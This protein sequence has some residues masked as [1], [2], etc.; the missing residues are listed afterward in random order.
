VPRI[1]LQ[2]PLGRARFVSAQRLPSALQLSPDRTADCANAAL[3]RL[4][5]VLGCPEFPQDL[6]RARRSLGASAQSARTVGST[7]R[8]WPPAGLRSSG[9]RGA[10]VVAVAPGMFQSPRRLCSALLQ[11]D[12][13]G[14]RRLPAPGLR[15]PS[16]PPAAAPRPAS[17]RLLAAASGA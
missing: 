12:A 6:R 4:P 1:P 7:R 17:P 3:V 16:S 5:L 13:P 9:A 14:L 10:A 11:R 8:P 2:L 15:R